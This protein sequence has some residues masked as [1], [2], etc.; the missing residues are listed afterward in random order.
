MIFSKINIFKKFLTFGIL[1]LFVCMGMHLESS[2]L[3]IPGDTSSNPILTDSMDDIES[4]V[5][6]VKDGETFEGKF[7]KLQKDIYLTRDGKKNGDSI[8]WESIG[9][10]GA[11]ANNNSSLENARPFKGTLD[12]N[13]K[14]LYINFENPP[15]GTS[16]DTAIFGFIGEGGTVKHLN[17]A[18]KLAKKNKEDRPTIICGTNLGLIEKCTVRLDDNAVTLVQEN[19][20]IVKK[21]KI[22]PRTKNPIKMIYNYFI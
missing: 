13:Y 22:K 5:Q 8:S 7:F 19:K 16:K 11:D 9:F 6:D 1:G 20:G 15:E 17:I 4:L 18:G 10:I 14:T 2:A 12:G 21:C 3:T